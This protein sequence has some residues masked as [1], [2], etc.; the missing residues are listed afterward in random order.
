MSIGTVSTG[1]TVVKAL[2]NSQPRLYSFQGH[3]TLLKLSTTRH[4][5]KRQATLDLVLRATSQSCCLLLYYNQGTF[6]NIFKEVP[7][8]GLNNFLLNLFGLSKGPD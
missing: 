7:K 3:F 4:D 8:F 6:E 5:L 1:G 2:G